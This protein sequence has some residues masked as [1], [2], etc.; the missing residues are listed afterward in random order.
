MTS[1]RTAPHGRLVGPAADLGSG[2][3]AL[4]LAVAMHRDG[5]L[6][7]HALERVAY[8]AVPKTSAGQTKSSQSAPAI[9]VPSPPS[10]PT[11]ELATVMEIVTR[12][13]AGDSEAFGQLYDRYVDVVYR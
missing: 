11:G 6:G 9:P 2:L 12:A 13:Q 1:R 4:R 3:A 5:Q 7:A 8:R 10:E